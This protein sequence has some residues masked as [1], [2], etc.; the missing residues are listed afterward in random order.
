MIF[1]YFI[2]II[3]NEIFFIFNKIDVSQNYKLIKNFYIILH[4]FLAELF[5][6]L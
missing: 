6:L 5:R 4:N 1:F 3:K 2:Y